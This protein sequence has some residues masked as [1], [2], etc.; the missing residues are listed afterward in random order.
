VL[1]PNG[2]DCDALPPLMARAADAPPVCVMVCRLTA[3]KN[4]ALTLEALARAR[5]VV[6]TLTL[7]VVGD[8]PERAALTRRA[9][10]LGIASAV[11]WHG[12]SDAPWRL[13]PADAIVVQSSETEGLSLS[14]IEAMAVGCRVVAT[15]VGQTRAFT[16]GALGVRLVPRGDAD[17]LARALVETV[18]QSPAVVEQVGAS[19]RAHARAHGSLATVVSALHTLYTETRP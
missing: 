13:V 2:V 14:L 8:G 17:A 15:D 16:D 7:Q 4:V 18:Q 3:V 5:A 12:V 9:D 1:L 19:N 11:Q 6:P 10:A